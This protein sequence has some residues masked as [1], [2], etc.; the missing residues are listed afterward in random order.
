MGEQALS[1][2]R[3]VD[4]RE[5]SPS[6]RHTVIAQLDRVERRLIGAQRFDQQEE[7][8]MPPTILY[9]AVATGRGGCED[10]SALSETMTRQIKQ[11]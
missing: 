11:G 10:R 2:E 5:I 7:R 6:V 4:V 3:V 8:S 9:T 1:K